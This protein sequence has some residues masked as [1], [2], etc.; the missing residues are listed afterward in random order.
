M[1]REEIAKIRQDA[2]LL[3]TSAKSLPELEQ[4]RIKLL[5]RKG[6]LT[7][8]LRGLSSL[9][10][11]ARKEIGFLANQTKEQLSVLLESRKVEFEKELETAAAAE[12]IDVTL[13]GRQL[14]KGT[15]HP[16]TQTMNEILEIFVGMG[17]QEELGPEVETEWY[18]YDA[19][20]F[21]PDHPARD[22]IACF[23]LGNGYLLRS[24]TSPVQI[25]VMEKKKPPVRIV[26]PGR[27]FRPDAFDASH[28]PVFYQVEGLY[29]D[30]GVSMADLKGTLEVFCKEMFG[31][32]TKARFSPSYFPFTEP[33]AEVAISC[34]V[35]GGSGCKTCKSSGWL[36][37]L[38]SG[39]VNPKVLENVGY[40]SVKY[41][42]FAFGM[43][44]ER[45]AMIKYGIDDIR[46][47]Y[48]NDLRFL[49]Q[50]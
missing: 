4:I 34:V 27:C 44:I 42:G 7:L 36:E 50:F 6:E 32:K 28:S 37:I 16:I 2:E 33:S 35:C 21:P 9:P 14:W 1:T 11:D 43:G 29:V 10:I 45:V 3:I 12:R 23:Q 5:G 47:F 19:L 24:H 40:D 18:N 30:E 38:G 8:I 26:A 13:P 41:T 31:E 20:N 39:M 17:F 48:D 15:K 49:E 22:M 46:L 25:R